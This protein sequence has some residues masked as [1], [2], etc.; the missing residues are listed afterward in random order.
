MSDAGGADPGPPPPPPPAPPAEV[1]Q[2]A[3]IVEHDAEARVDVIR[4]APSGDTGGY[5]IILPDIHPA[6]KPQP[7]RDDIALEE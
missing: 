6:R 4:V 1:V 5:A 7:V 2:A 3:D